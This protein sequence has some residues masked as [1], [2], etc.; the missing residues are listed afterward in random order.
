MYSRQLL[1][2]RSMLARQ[3]FEPTGA[4]GTKEIP[5]PLF[6]TNFKATVLS[7]SAGFERAASR[8]DWKTTAL[9]REHCYH[10]RVDHANS[11]SI[12]IV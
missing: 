8:V 7:D 3:I 12:F 4:Q 2:A 10:A 5:I 6:V 11:I 1:Q 9:P